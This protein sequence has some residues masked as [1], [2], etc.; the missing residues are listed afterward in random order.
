M[1][2]VP[3]LVLLDVYPKRGPSQ[4]LDIDKSEIDRLVSEFKAEILS[5][6]LVVHN[7]ND[8]LKEVTL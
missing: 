4:Q 6:T 2:Q 1:K 8:D 5:R 3:L 7:I